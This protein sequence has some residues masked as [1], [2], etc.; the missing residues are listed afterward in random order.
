MTEGTKKEF[1]VIGLLPSLRQFASTL[2][3]DP[4]R[5]KLLVERTLRRA[6]SELKSY[7]IGMDLRRW[8]FR[9]M[10]ETAELRASHGKIALPA[11][12]DR[13]RQSLMS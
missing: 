6:V 9:L 12:R 3:T 5:S 8:L 2:E 13:S 11:R 10:L 7:R 1:D 4:Q